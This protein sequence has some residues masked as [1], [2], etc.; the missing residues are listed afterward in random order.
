L[1]G[2]LTARPQGKGSNWGRQQKCRPLRGVKVG[3]EL[4]WQKTKTVSN[5]VE[6]KS[7]LII[8]GGLDSVV[9]KTG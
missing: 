6:S 3:G 1:T 5:P 8:V 9:P 2:F 7:R 4:S